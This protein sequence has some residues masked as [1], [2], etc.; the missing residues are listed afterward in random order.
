M[1]VTSEIFEGVSSFVKA[2]TNFAEIFEKNLDSYFRIKDKLSA[3][4]QLESIERVLRLFPQIWFFNGVF[5][6]VVR[7]V[8]SADYIS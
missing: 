6:A 3:R 1:S 4:H 8:K 2:A 7:D 5:L